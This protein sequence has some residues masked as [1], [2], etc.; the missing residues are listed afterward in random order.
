MPPAWLKFWGINYCKSCIDYKYSKGNKL[1]MDLNSTH[2]FVEEEKA[3]LLS[4]GTL[5]TIFY[6]PCSI[7]E[8]LKSCTTA[9]VDSIECWTLYHE[10]IYRLNE[11]YFIYSAIL[12]GKDMTVMED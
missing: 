1:A 8:V 6:T 9:S 11:V 10:I 5:L 3:S 7:S 4:W 2:I 12:E